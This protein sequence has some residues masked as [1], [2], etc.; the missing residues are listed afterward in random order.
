MPAFFDCTVLVAGEHPA[1]AMDLD[2]SLRRLGCTVLGPAD[3]AETGMFLARQQRPS[4][5]L[6]HLTPLG[7]RG[8]ESL[9]KLLALLEVPFATVGTTY[10]HAG[11]PPGLLRR[12]ARLSKPY[13]M[14]SLHRLVREL[15]VANLQLK[16]DA[17]EQHIVAG[18]KRLARQVHLAEKL[19]TARHN[20]DNAQVLA[21]EIGRALRLMRT[22]R[23]LFADQLDE[24]QS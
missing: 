15:Q 4:L 8:F 3:S 14:G 21:R 9:A 18:T 20:T 24:L 6:L 19:A 22:S 1:T 7:T 11:L 13:D 16:I 17:I 12:V 10:E 2:D 23:R 5:A